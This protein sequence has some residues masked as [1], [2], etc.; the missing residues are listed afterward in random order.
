M[1]IL[2]GFPP[3]G[4]VKQRWDGKTSYFLLLSVNISKIGKSYV[5]SYYNWLNR[6]SHT[7]SIGINIDN[8]G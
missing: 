1:L 5:Q 3:P 2:Q 7:L 4:G 6:K 8:L